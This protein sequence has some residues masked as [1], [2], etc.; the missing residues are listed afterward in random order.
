MTIT[1]SVNRSTL[2]APRSKSKP[3]CSY[4]D[5]MLPAPRPS[6]HPPFVRR[7]TAAASRA[8]STGWRRS[9][10]RTFVP[11]RSCFVA[12]AAIASAGTGAMRSVRWSG[13][14]SVA[15]PSAST[16]R[17]FSTRS[18]RD[19]TCQMLTPN[20]NGFIC[21]PPRPFDRPSQSP[22]RAERQ[23][24]NARPPPKTSCIQCAG[25]RSRYST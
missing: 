11:T 22:D 18:A 24:L 17:A 21:L 1:A 19:C 8:T 3:T 25:G 20:R 10:F 12:S 6:S 9:L 15:Y 16:L 5:R 2:T 7:S 4:S 14:V 23:S 13:K